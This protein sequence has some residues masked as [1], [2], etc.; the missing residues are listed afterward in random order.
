[1]LT[2]SHP[3]RYRVYWSDS[4]ETAPTWV[5][6][7]WVDVVDY[8]PS[9]YGHREFLVNPDYIPSVSIDELEDRDAMELDEAARLMWEQDRALSWSEPEPERRDED[10]GLGNEYENP[11]GDDMLDNPFLYHYGALDPTEKMLCAHAYN[12]H[13]TITKTWKRNDI[14]ATTETIENFLVADVL[15]AL[16]AVV[17]EVDIHSDLAKQT[18]IIIA[19]LERRG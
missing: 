18:Y 11:Y 12:A 9:T 3:G 17:E 14:R 15:K 2:L 8:G 7:G 4:W 10:V 13:K 19:K 16:R 5:E 1:M 6:E